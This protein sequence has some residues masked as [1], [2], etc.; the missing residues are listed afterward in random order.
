MIGVNEKELTQ[1]IQQF[2]LKS[3]EESRADMASQLNQVL[4][5]RKAMIIKKVKKFAAEE[6]ATQIE[7]IN[8]KIQLMSKE[9]LMNKNSLKKSSD[10]TKPDL[11]EMRLFR[12]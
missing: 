11:L 9:I 1:K 6:R 8:K 2:V 5:K 4:S 10:F 12:S 3:E 7:E